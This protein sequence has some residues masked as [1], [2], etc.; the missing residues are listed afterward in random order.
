MGLVS[1]C[2]ASLDKAAHVKVSVYLLP[3]KGVGKHGCDTITTDINI[4]RN[5]TDYTGNQFKLPALHIYMH[6]APFHNHLSFPFSLDSFYNKYSKESCGSQVVSF[7][8]TTRLF[9]ASSA[10]I[11][12]I[13]ARYLRWSSR[14][15]SMTLTASSLASRI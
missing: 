10:W 6:V 9:G 2:G 12:I 8:V 1:L 5:L 4:S 13:P 14:V 3:R 7:L 15:K 11:A